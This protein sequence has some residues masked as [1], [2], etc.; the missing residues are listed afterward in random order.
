[1]RRRSARTPAA[2]AAETPAAPSRDNVFK[3]IFK[4]NGDHAE[5]ARLW[6]DN[7]DRFRSKVDFLRSHLQAPNASST[8]L[9]RWCNS[10]TRAL[11][12]LDAPRALNGVT[13]DNEPVGKV[14]FGNATDGTEQQRGWMICTYGCRRYRHCHKY[15]DRLSMATEMVALFLAEDDEHTR[16]NALHLEYEPS[17]G[18]LCFEASRC[19]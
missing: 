4:D 2:S 9:N 12:K 10:L 18:D 16:H 11:K 6:L 1:M 17:R 15:E 14:Y 8:D 3:D 7:E 13:V 5:A 19:S